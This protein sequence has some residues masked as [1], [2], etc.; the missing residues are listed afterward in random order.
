[1]L[2]SVFDTEIPALPEYE[3]KKF[4]AEFLGG[5]GH[6]LWWMQQQG[7]NVPPAL[8]IPTT[9]CVEYMKK[10]KTVMKDIAKQ[11]A[12]IEKFFKGKFGYMPLLSV[13][14]GARVSMPGMMDTI[15]NVGLDEST[16]AFWKEKIGGA[17]CADSI[18]RLITMYGNVVHNISRH[19]LE[20]D[21]VLSALAVFEKSV[22]SPFPKAKEQVLGAIEAVFKSWNN[23]RAKFYRKMHDI[24]E[25]W[26]T[27]VVV[28][29]MVFGNLNDNSCTGVMFTRNPDNGDG[30]VVGEYLV[31]AQG[32]DVVAGIR[33]PQNLS[34]MSNW[35]DVVAQEVLDVALKLEQ[36]KRDV[37]DIEFTVQDGKLYILQTRNAKRSAR[38]AVKIAVEMMTEGLITREEMA[39]RVSMKEL[40]LAQ[41]SILDPAFTDKEDFTGI[42]ACSGVVTGRVVLSAQAAINCKEPCIMVTQETTPDDIAG[43]NAAK[44]VLTMTGGST[45]HAA[46]VARGM[47]KPCVVGLSVD[48]KKF[49]DGAIIS[50]DG[51]TGRVWF[52][53]VPV[54]DGSS[55]P[56][57]L[58]FKEACWTIYNGGKNAQIVDRPKP[59]KVQVVRMSDKISL[60]WTEL[61]KE[62]CDVGAQADQIVLDFSPLHEV[63][64]KF[65]GMFL[66]SDRV[67]E[68]M[69][70]L[71]PMLEQSTIANKL[72]IL[73]SKVSAKLPCLPVAQALE[74]LILAEAEVIWIGKP[75]PAADKVLKWKALE[76]VKF[77]AI[78]T[79]SE[80]GTSYVSESQMLG[81]LLR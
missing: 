67:V 55:N 47:N 8:I 65:Y 7:V 16:E 1:M 68:L 28:Q 39:K 77:S 78:G 22:G 45:S 32:E 4:D 34:E 58:Q 26:G 63:E 18:H 71:M 48:I 69:N 73:G 40:D 30:K 3:G 15:L 27:A 76:G 52:G 33:T 80:G 43:M 9:M 66:S 64:A 6:G 56:F 14:S 35:N 51:A 12:N 53:K 49:K 36:A 20:K 46:V 50:I 11:Y 25:E 72:S 37:Q 54:I 79:A 19:E 24:P 75:S 70:T 61:L 44:A 42:P 10:P 2:I 57:V 31:N 41:Q 59:L 29:A 13:R 23:D 74:E 62:L 81:S 60:H 21:D 38:A 5:K 17:A